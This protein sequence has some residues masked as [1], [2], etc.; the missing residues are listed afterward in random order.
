[1]FDT[2]YT[3]AHRR[4]QKQAQANVDAQFSHHPN[5]VAGQF[6]QLASFEKRM[7]NDILNRRAKTPPPVLD[8]QPTIYPTKLKL[9][10]R[11]QQITQFGSVFSYLHTKRC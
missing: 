10:Q 11:D 7:H 9:D 5:L 6:R 4:K 2:L 1:M 8:F 3:E